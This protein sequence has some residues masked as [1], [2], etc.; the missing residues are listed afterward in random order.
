[1]PK[2]KLRLALHDLTGFE[3]RCDAIL[4]SSDPTFVPPNKDPEMLAFRHQ[5]LGLSDE[6]ERAG[7]YDL[8]VTGGGIAGTCAAVTAARL[9][10]M[11][12]SSR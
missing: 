8:V 2:G 10:S 4:F 11:A 1:L 6:P 9:N 5:C 3:G 7:E 12:V